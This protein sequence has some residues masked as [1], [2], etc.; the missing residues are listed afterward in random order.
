MKEDLLWQ[1]FVKTG[2]VADYLA[3]C[4]VKTQKEQ[5]SEVYNR[6][7]DNQRNACRRK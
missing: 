7:F 6:R 5:S 3:Y 2:S 1:E 4:Q